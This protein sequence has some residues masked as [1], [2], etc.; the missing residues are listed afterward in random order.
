[1][2][3]WAKDALP[4]G[5]PLCVPPQHHG[6][7]YRTTHQLFLDITICTDRMLV[8]SK[9]H[10]LY[11]LLNWAFNIVYTSQVLIFFPFVL[12]QFWFHRT[13]NFLTLATKS[14]ALR[15][16]S[17]HVCAKLSWHVSSRCL[18]LCCLDS[19]VLSVIQI[20]FISFCHI[21]INCKYVT[22]LWCVYLAVIFITVNN[23]WVSCNFLCNWIWTAGST[24][25]P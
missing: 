5:H 19:S 13:I 15:S 12:V 14:L 22:F 20:V 9:L 6:V 21:W 8:C 4:T 10:C 11:G 3:Y 24:S 23:T 25:V 16:R 2:H 1:M 18:A 17:N 7:L